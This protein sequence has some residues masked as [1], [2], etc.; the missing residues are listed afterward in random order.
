MTDR[1]AAGLYAGVPSGFFMRHHTARYAIEAHLPVNVWMVGQSEI[2][3]SSPNK[4]AALFDDVQ[5]REF[6]HCS[7]E[8]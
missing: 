6:D 5:R 2:S 3:S 7:L 4:V 1:Y 8:S